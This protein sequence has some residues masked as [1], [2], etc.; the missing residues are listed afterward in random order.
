MI[1]EPPF[2]QSVFTDDKAKSMHSAWHNW[3]F[4]L[5]QRWGLFGDIKG[6]NYAEIDKTGLLKL[7]GDATVWKDVFFPQAP[8]KTT[9]AGN[10]SLVSWNGNLRGYAY[11]VNDAHDFD[12]QEF[13]HDGKQG[14]TTGSWHIHWINRTNVGAT[15]AVK[16]QLEFSQANP[17]GVFPAATTVSVEAEIPANT[18]A[19]THYLTH[20]S[21][22][23]TLNIASQMF[24]RLKRIAPAGTAPADDPVII[25]V[26]YHYELDQM[27]SSELITK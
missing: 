18:A 23:T 4:A 26:H 14:A 12:P 15:R 19:N 13:P 5:F 7:H 2:Q 10:P 6:G 9:G 22:F 24:V 1:Q 11:S 21:N 8:P 20:I 25:G 27:G 17:S 16:F 3:L